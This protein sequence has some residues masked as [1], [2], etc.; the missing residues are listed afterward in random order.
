MS[1]VILDRVV[2]LTFLLLAVVIIAT[3]LSNS[4]NQDS[5]ER[6]LLEIAALRQDFRK[7]MD[8]NL[9]YLE[10][11][12]NKQAEIQDDYQVSTSRRLDIME[13]NIK[14][15]KKENKDLKLQQK[16]IINNTNTAT[17]IANGKKQ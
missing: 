3:L 13:E 14:S 10:K 16:N 17:A 9:N 5:Q 4:N 7:V 8:A 1:W 2:N 12:Q 11:R 6:F 15:L